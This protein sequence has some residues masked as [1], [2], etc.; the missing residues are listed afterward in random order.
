[1]SLI[2]PLQQG[3]MLQV[4]AAISNLIPSIDTRVKFLGDAVGPII[5][6]FTSQ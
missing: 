3:Q 4:T 1:M 6:F 2:S 5:T